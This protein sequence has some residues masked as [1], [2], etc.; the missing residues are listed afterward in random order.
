MAILVDSIE[1]SPNPTTIRPR[2]RI[3]LRQDI[4]SDQPSESIT[5]VYSLSQEHDMF[6]EE[7]G[8]MTKEAQRVCKV[9]GTGTATV[10][11]VTLVRGAGNELAAY[12]IEQVLT[13]SDGRRTRRSK[14]IVAA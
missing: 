9:F 3:E 7:Q 13:D 2:R 1:A 4:Q 12:G 6:F 10:H 11:R 8:Q 5:I 14:S